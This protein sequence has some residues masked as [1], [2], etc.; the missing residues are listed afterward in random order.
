MHIEL[1]GSFNYLNS[2]GER[3]DSEMERWGWGPEVVFD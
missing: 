3:E 1:K 2:N